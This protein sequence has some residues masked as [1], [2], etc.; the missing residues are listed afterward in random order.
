MTTILAMLGVFL[1]AGLLMTMFM[2]YPIPVILILGTIFV[3]L[4]F[5]VQVAIV[6]GIIVGGLAIAYVVSEYN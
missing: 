5:P 4:M 1:L 3:I 2:V 6:I